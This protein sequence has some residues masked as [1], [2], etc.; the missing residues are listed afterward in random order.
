MLSTSVCP[1]VYSFLVSANRHLI[2]CQ[3]ATSI[4]AAA[5]VMTRKVAQPK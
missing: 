1:V 3:E 5:A 2:S 4:P